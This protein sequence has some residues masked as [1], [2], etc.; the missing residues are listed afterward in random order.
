MIDGK[1]WRSG[2]VVERKKLNQWFFK[3]SKFS[4]ELLD[5]LDELK[6]WPN[7]VKTMQ[8]IGLVSL[9]DAK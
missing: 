8:K 4:Q 1:G 2:A 9:L 5:G 6:T 3:I 7:K